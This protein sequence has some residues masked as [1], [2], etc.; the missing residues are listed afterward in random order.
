MV[1]HDQRAMAY[2]DRVIEIADGRILTQYDEPELV[3][4]EYGSR[5][6]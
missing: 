6:S 2:A 5:A 3:S 1:T 4:A